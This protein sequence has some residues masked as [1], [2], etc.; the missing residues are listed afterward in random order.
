MLETIFETQRISTKR[1]LIAS[2]SFICFSLISLL[3]FGV[4]FGASIWPIPMVWIL[5]GSHKFAPDFRL[6]LWLMVLGLIADLLFAVPLGLYGACAI[7]SVLM[8]WLFH[9]FSPIV[10]TGVRNITIIAN[11]AYLLS[12]VLIGFLIGNLPNLLGLLIPSLATILLSPFVFNLFD[13][14]AGNKNER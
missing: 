13:L 4:L 3:Q 8:L 2:V 9:K 7:L 12:C 6:S 5:S 11:L 14:S 10:P 1:L